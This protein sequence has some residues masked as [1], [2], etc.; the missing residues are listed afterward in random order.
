MEPL[1]HSHGEESHDKHAVDGLDEALRLHWNHWVEAAD[2]GL[3]QHRGNAFREEESD[4]V[5]HT[6]LLW[7]VRSLVLQECQRFTFESEAV[8]LGRDVR[9]EAAGV[10][11]LA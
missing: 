9:H 4:S 6:A 8:E 7:C 2:P 5:S 10:L 1:R 11:P 3:E